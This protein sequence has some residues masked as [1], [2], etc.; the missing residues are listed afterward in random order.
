M[1]FMMNIIQE[2]LTLLPDSPGVYIMLDK[3]GIVIYVG[4]ARVLKNRVRQYFHTSAKSD[5]VLA[6]VE[7][8]ADFSYIMQN[9]SL[10]NN[11]TLFF[12]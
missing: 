10:F 1:W 8:I 5:K 4:K 6:M 12:R 7:H 3:D 2:K 11:L 9:C